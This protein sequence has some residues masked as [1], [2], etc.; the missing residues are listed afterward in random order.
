MSQT[1]TVSG[2][3][4]SDQTAALL[5]H[6]ASEGW[7]I[8]P[9]SRG[10]G[11]PNTVIAYPADKTQQPITVS[12]RCAKYN[13][14]HYENLRR[15][16]YRAGLSPLPADASPA[17]TGVVD[18]DSLED[19]QSRL[20]AGAKSVSLPDLI[21]SLADGTDSDFIDFID[22]IDSPERAPA[23]IG[24]LVHG[25]LHRLGVSI[26]AADAA[27][28]NVTMAVN[29]ALATRVD[30]DAIVGAA[31]ARLETEVSEALAMAQN[32]EEKYDRANRAAA[33]A[34]EKE[35]A[36]RR[37]CGEA[38]AQARAEKARADE[39]EAALAPLRTLLGK[40]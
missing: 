27:A 22:S 10:R 1:T 26:P 34:A 29:L 35:A 19:V 39:L 14:A 37:D 7:R 9:D 12:E 17:P 40:A 31:T 38:L 11:K 32:A 25:L 30:V 21:R 13:R 5:D 4:F 33:K 23:A 18:G 24:A 16:C 20:P 8:E 36:A 6:A 2:I 3:K 28:M 15:E